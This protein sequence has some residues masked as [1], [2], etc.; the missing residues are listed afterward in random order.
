MYIY[1][2]NFKDYL[3]A[4]KTFLTLLSSMSHMLFVLLGPEFLKATRYPTS[5]SQ[6]V[7]AKIEIVVA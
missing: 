1:F 3:Y 7:L 4:L 2:M 5:T 6:N